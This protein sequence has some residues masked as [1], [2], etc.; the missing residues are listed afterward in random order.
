[1]RLLQS[2]QHKACAD[3]TYMKE[4]MLDEPLSADFFE[5]LKHFGRVE[6]LEALGD[7]YYNFTKEGWFSIKGFSGDTSVEVR[8]NRDVMDMV[9]GFL[10]MLFLRYR[11][12]SGQD[13]ADIAELKEKEKALEEQIKRM[14]GR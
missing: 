11:P 5:Y 2:V 7:G 4:Y 1:M 10:R 9:S 3:G 14:K 8:F 12:G 13:G 6:A